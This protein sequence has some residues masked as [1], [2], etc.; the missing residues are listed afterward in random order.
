MFIYIFVLKKQI[1][2]VF[3]I[4]IRNEVSQLLTSLLA[5]LTALERY[6]DF[7]A[8]INTEAALGE[9]ITAVRIKN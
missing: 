1:H 3:M 7:L 8:R 6:E 9:P 4:Q 5:R 2:F